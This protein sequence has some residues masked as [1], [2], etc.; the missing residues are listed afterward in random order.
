MALIKAILRKAKIIILKDT[1]WIIGGVKVTDLIKEWKLNCTVIGITCDLAGTDGAERLVYMEK[2]KI[3]EDDLV[4]TL[5]NN[6]LSLGGALLR[7]SK[8]QNYSFLQGEEEISLSQV[9]KADVVKKGTGNTV[10]K[11]RKANTLI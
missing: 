11:Y 6:E 4:E 5:L 1:P 2:L 9:L 10:K 8:A 7:A 3:M